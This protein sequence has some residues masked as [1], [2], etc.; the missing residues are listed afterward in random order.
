MDAVADMEREFRTRAT[1]DDGIG[2]GTLASPAASSAPAAKIDPSKLGADDARDVLG[3][4]DQTRNRGAR[5]CLPGGERQCDRRR[6][7]TS[8]ASNRTRTRLSPMVAT[9]DATYQAASNASRVGR[10]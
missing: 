9:K 2:E 5:G 6:E 10:P 1:D 3:R 7:S 4:P 8:P